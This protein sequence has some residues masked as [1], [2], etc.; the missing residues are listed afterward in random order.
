M[1]TLQKKNCLQQFIDLLWNSTNIFSLRLYILSYLIE[2]HIF[3]EALYPMKD[4]QTSTTPKTMKRTQISE[5]G[6]QKIQNDK[7]LFC[8]RQ[9]WQGGQKV[10]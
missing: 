3:T 10:V 7:T 4:S 5:Y 9:V 1:A 8:Y 2:I 6:G